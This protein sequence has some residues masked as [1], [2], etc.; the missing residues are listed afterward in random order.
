MYLSGAGIESAA[1]PDGS[2][3]V[4]LIPSNCW[5]KIRSGILSTARFAGVL[6]LGDHRLAVY[7]IAD[8][9]ISWQLRA[10]GSLFHNNYGEYEMHATG[11]FLVCGNGKREEV[12]ERIIRTAM[13]QRR[14]LISNKDAGVRDKPVRYVKAPIRLVSQYRHVYLTTPE[15]LGQ[16]IGEIARE[17]DYIA[18]LQGDSPGCPA[19]KSKARRGV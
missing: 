17:E 11:M 15:L 4:C 7:D 5:R 6:F 10:E 2:N 3:G 12:A 8:G 9:A 18:P 14:Q 13:W 19:K 16:S 1:S